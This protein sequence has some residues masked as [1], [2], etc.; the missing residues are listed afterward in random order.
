MDG[1]R[2]DEAIALFRAAVAD[3]PYSWLVGDEGGAKV[4]FLSFF[5]PLPHIRLSTEEQMASGIIDAVYEGRDEVYIFEFKFDR[6]SQEAFNQI[7]E[8]GYARPYLG[9]GKKAMALVSI[10]TRTK[11]SAALT[12]RS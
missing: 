9:T 12:S 10:S 2:L 4:L 6:S 3:C 5:Y 1:K 7:I 8:R 11:M